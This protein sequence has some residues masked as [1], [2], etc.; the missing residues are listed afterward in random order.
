MPLKCLFLR[1]FLAL[2]L[3]PQNRANKLTS[4]IVRP[5]VL[6]G[7]FV[8]KDTRL[9]YRVLGINRNYF[10]EISYKPWFVCT[11]LRYIESIGCLSTKCLPLVDESVPQIKSIASEAVGGLMEMCNISNDMWLN[12]KWPQSS[13]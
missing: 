6:T 7:I 1:C 2:K 8:K 10:F 9:F 3:I 13:L 12:F 5:R 11:I 4:C